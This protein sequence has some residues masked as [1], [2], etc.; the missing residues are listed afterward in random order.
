MKGKNMYTSQRQQIEL[1]TQALALAITAPTNQK[2]NECIE[3]AYSFMRGLPAQTVERCKSEA[4]R[5]AGL[6]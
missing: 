6:I 5:M 1:L 3:M 4:S 2:A